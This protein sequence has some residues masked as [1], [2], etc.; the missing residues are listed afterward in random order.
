MVVHL[1]ANAHLD[2]IWLWNWQAG[3]DEALATF[4]SAVDRC[5]EYPEFRY[6]RGESWLYQWVEE[7]DPG[8]FNEVRA[9]IESGRWSIAGGQLIQPDA[10]LP[11]AAGWKKQ[12]ELGQ[13]Y[14][15]DRFGVSPRIGYNVDTFGHPATLPDILCD[16]GYRGYVFHRPN[17]SQVKLPA[18]TFRWRGSG[19]SE[20]L[21]FRIAPAYV[22]RS[23]DLEGQIDLSVKAADPALGHT[24]MFY[25]LGN[26]GGGPTK[27]NI[28]WL[29]KHQNSFGDVE[30]RFSTV[31]EF[32]SAAEAKRDLVPIVDYELQKTFPG[33]YSVMHDVKQVQHRT[34]RLL[35]QA[36]ELAHAFCTGS[37]S[38]HD[39]I[40]RINTAW[41]DLAFTQFHDIL[42]G[43][44][45]PSSYV[46]TRHM[47]GRAGIIGEEE[48]VRIS[49][50]HAR[51]NLPCEDVQRLVILN[52]SDHSF[53]G[54]VE[55]EPFIDFDDWG[56]RWFADEEGN[57]VPYQLI[58]SEPNTGPM[59]HRA[60]LPLE[61]SAKGSRVLKLLDAAEGEI[62]PP[63]DPVR[64]QGLCLSNGKLSAELSPNGIRSLKWNGK[65]F[66][67]KEGISLQLREDQGDTWVF[68]NTAFEEALAGNLT[69]LEWTLEDEGPIR[70]RMFADQTLGDSK[71]RIAVTVYEGKPEVHINLH[72]VFSERHKLLQLPIHL[73]AYPNTWNSGLAG[74]HVT[75]KPGVDEMPFCGW[76]SVQMP[77]ASLSLHT[78]DT[79]SSRLDGD[80]WQF[81]LLRSPLMAWTGD[82]ELKPA[83][84]RRFSDQGWH[85]FHFI[86][87]FDE[88]FDPTR[89]EH[90]SAHQAKPP[91]LFD[92]Y[93]GMNRPAWG[94]APPRRLWTPDIPHARSLG[95]MKHLDTIADEG[96]NWEESPD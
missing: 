96:R 38:T 94:N 61:V 16:V 82:S 93:V 6:T 50:R 95:F 25:G 70:A 75:R 41:H 45:V 52:G 4:R 88:S 18:Q 12:I 66:L 3:V 36:E 29:L 7:L 67:G 78:P 33:C 10:N 84:S 34:E 26:H 42:A 73:Q 56:T 22:T 1:I 11:T 28:E 30:L 40:E 87:R 62:P 71:I 60:V 55:C 21:G 91:V 27:A 14:F 17:E 2:P 5:H 85:D 68:H 54:H 9:L 76:D 35:E 23:D 49:R 8:L 57:P 39:S 81:T 86:L 15:K 13:R 47:Q 74:G 92:H 48:I 44:S 77:G 58:T 51:A 59:M 64:L 24:M 20:I 31:D 63:V 79:Y 72:V 32:Y 90:S 37:K 80:T 43:T 19:G 89:C 83:F 69:D 53:D 46:S 65:E